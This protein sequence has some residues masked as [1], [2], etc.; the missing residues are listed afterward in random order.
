METK[1]NSLQ[2]KVYGRYALFSDPLTRPGGEKFSYQTPTYQALKGIVESVY[3]KPILIWY[4][5]AVR[6]MKRIQTQSKGIRPIKMNGGNDLAY[7]TYLS[8][9]EYQILAHFEWNPYRPELSAD[10]DEH[11]H[12]NIAKRSVRQ[13][14]RR[15]VFL[16]TRECQAYV[17]PCVFG[18]GAGAYD[19]VDGSHS[20]IDFGMMFHGFDYPDETGKNELCARL[21]RQKMVDGVI[22][23]QRPEA[24]QARRTVREYGG[25]YS[26][27]RFE[28][29][30][31]LSDELV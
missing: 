27:K 26:F 12:H 3:W 31:N 11:K 2:L 30:V 21:W 13:G 24:V 8:D 28:E 14:G 15:D 25:A 16:G 4:I 18:E 29:G 5:D 9:V 23:F 17:E 22:E 6:V 10:R 19:S 20:E 7:Y 1:R